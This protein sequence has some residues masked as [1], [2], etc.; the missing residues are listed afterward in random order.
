MGEA[1]RF[2]IYS[3]FPYPIASPLSTSPTRVK[4]LLHPMNLW[5]SLVVQMVKHLPAMQETQVRSLGWEDP[6][7]Y[8]DTSVTPNP[9]AWV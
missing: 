6:L 4:D 1:Q 9:C 2:L 7:I 3:L 8:I 5:A